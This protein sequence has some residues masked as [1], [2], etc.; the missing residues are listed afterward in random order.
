MSSR[1]ART[2]SVVAA[3]ALAPH[4]RAASSVNVEGYG[5]WQNLEPSLRA[6][7]QATRGNEGT[8]ILGGDILLRLEGLGVG[9]SVDK[10]VSGTFQ[11]WTGSLMAG[12]LADIAVVRL[13]ILGE[14]G[15]RGV[16]SFDNLFKD[17]GQTFV[18]FR[19]GVSFRILPSPFR[20][21]VSALIRWPTSN[22]DFGSPDYGA[23]GRLGIE[24]P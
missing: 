22:G 12:F 6:V 14:L 20:I 15:R 23:L 7:G 13:E 24:F 16:D 4:V 5:G 8:A 19:P 2:L 9:A 1:V 11:P 21:G 3:L 18:G 17:A 10:T